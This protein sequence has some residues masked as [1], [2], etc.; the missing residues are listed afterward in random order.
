VTEITSGYGLWNLLF[1]VRLAR[2]ETD[3]IHFREE[4]RGLHL[5]RHGGLYDWGDDLRTLIMRRRLSEPWTMR[6]EERLRAL[7]AQGAS[8]LRAALALRRS[9]EYIRDRANKMGCP[10]PHLKVVRLK[11]ANT[12]NNEWRQN[13]LKAADP[14]D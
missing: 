9:K 8:L 14:N 13:R 3:T 12:P 4:G 2:H 7:V 11:W 6:D 1:A 5:D 10:F